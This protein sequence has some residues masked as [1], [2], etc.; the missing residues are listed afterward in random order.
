MTSSVAVVK[1]SKLLWGSASRATNYRKHER[2]HLHKTVD[3]VGE[4]QLRR[5][6]LL[7]LLLLL[8]LLILMMLW[9]LTLPP[10]LLLL[11]LDGQVSARSR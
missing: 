4:R 7:L 6:V 9:L 2:N 5:G 10:H 1:E 11:L 3:P 8:L